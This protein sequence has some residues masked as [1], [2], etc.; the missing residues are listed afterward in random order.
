MKKTLLLLAHL[1]SR[2]ACL[3]AAL[4]LPAALATV[5]PPA[6]AAVAEAWVHRYNGP[7]FG[8]QETCAIKEGVLTLDLLKD[9]FDLP[10]IPKPQT[11]FIQDQL[12]F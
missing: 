7:E 2:R 11:T 3:W 6:R 10:K 12:P 5:A 1:L 9:S 8:V 4:G